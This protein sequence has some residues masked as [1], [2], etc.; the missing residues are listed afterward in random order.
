M[1][2]QK[3][4]HTLDNLGVEVDLDEGDMPT[5]AVVLVKVIKE[6]G[7]VSMTKGRSETLDWINALGMLTAAQAIENSG[8]QLAEDD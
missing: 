8:Y 1:G 7:S 6:D 5:D 4:G 3:I 2:W